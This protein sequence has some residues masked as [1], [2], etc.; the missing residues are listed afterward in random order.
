[1]DQTPI[2]NL[3]DSLVHRC[4]GIFTYDLG[5]IGIL[6]APD[7]LTIFN[8][9]VWSIRGQCGTTQNFGALD[10][11]FWTIWEM[12][13]QRFPIRARFE[14]LLKCSRTL[15]KIGIQSTFSSTGLSVTKV[16][17]LG[18]PGTLSRNLYVIDT[19]VYH[20]PAVACIADVNRWLGRPGHA[21]HDGIKRHMQ[22]EFQGLK[23]RYPVL[24]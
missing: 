20:S 19:P 3:V 12:F 11:S 8:L 23:F 21:L 24:I 1:M 17:N 13:F 18:V 16:G 22:K 4:W 15:S 2:E 10:Q 5:P 9:N 14:I 7:S 6:W